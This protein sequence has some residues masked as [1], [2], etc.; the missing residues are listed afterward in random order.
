LSKNDDLHISHQENSRINTKDI[1]KYLER[2][3]LGR[4]Y[5]L[6]EQGYAINVNK[7]GTGSSK[8]F[9][10]PHLAITHQPKNLIFTHL[11][12]RKPLEAIFE[13]IFIQKLLN[14][15]V[16]VYAPNKISG[17]I[18]AVTSAQDLFLDQDI[19]AEAIPI[20]LKGNQSIIID[21]TASEYKQ[22]LAAALQNYNTDFESPQTAAA[23]LM[24]NNFKTWMWNHPSYFNENH[25]I[26]QLLMKSHNQTLADHD[27]VFENSDIKLKAGDFKNLL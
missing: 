20:E 18:E 11:T 1:L 25:A 9:K 24:A 10:K 6:S 7:I 27:I 3:T 4:S 2:P 14:N 13:A 5:T 16:P 19:Q 12:A 15:G 17:K 23:H 22:F 26:Q 8:I 21:N